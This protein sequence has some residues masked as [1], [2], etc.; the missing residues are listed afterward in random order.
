MNAIVESAEDTF[1][2]PVLL[3]C[4][5]AGEAKSNAV[6]GEECA[7]RRVIK[8]FAF[9]GLETHNGHLKL[10]AYKGMEGDESG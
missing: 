2:T 1:C 7:R 9:V 3:G 8:L 4:V 6:R 10:S 5:W